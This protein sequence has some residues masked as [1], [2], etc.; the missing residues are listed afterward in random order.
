MCDGGVKATDHAVGRSLGI[1]TRAEKEM[2]LARVGRALTTICLIA[3][4]DALVTALRRPSS[5][6]N[7][8]ARAGVRLQLFPGE[9]PWEFVRQNARQR[10]AEHMAMEEAER[11]EPLSHAYKAAYAD[12]LV[13]LEV[14]DAMAGKVAQR[15]HSACARSRPCGESHRSRRRRF[16]P[17]EAL[18]PCLGLPL[19]PQGPPR[20]KRLLPPRSPGA[21][22]IPRRRRAP[23]TERQPQGKVPFDHAGP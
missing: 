18:P 4:T 9:D 14:K 8:A 6:C 2:V 21:F 23:G 16:D 10:A 17:Q 22:S 7:C 1:S 20:S 19:G 5:R 13:D 11:G 15:G 3:G 12:L